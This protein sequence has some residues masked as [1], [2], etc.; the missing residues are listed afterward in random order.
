MDDSL[1]V[2][3]C[4][5]KIFFVVIM[6]SVICF[7]FRMQEEDILEHIIDKFVYTYSPPTLTGVGPPAN[8]EYQ[9]LQPVALTG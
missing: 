5:G 1:R 8:G 7:H 3:I 6:A 4:K 9:R 2:L